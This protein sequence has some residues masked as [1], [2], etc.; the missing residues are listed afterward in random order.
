MVFQLSGKWRPSGSVM[1]SQY[2]SSWIVWYPT[3]K[4]VVFT[5]VT[6]SMLENVLAGFFSM[7]ST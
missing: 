5:V 1:V 2:T 7:S 4:G 6:M 3:E